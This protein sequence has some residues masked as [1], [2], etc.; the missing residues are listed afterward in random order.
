MTEILYRQLKSQP[1]HFHAGSLGRIRVLEMS[2]IQLLFLSVDRPSLKPLRSA[3][4]KGVAD[5]LARVGFFF[6]SLQLSA[7]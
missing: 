4:K 1:S 7:R 3:L 6:L 2:W 5:E